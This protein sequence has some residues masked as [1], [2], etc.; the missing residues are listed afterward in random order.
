MDNA[1]VDD[2]PEGE[3]GCLG[4]CGF[5]IENLQKE[6]DFSFGLKIF[7]VE[8]YH[9]GDEGRVFA[10]PGFNIKAMEVRSGE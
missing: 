8:D 1:E 3:R 6:K 10:S 2:S 5:V 7:V 9:L 4:C